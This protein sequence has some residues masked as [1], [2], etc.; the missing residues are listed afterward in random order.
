MRTLKITLVL[1][2]AASLASAGSAD[3]LTP[4]KR[5]VREMPKVSLAKM[6]LMRVLAHYE[7]LSGLTLQADWEALGGAGVTKETPVTLKAGKLTFDKLLDL[8]LNSAAK[9]GRPL[10]WYLS[11]STVHVSTQMRVILRGR[12]RFAGRVRPRGKSPVR[13]RGTYS[14]AREIN[15]DKTPLHLAIEFLRDLAGTNFH[16]NWRALEESGISR[17][18]PVTVKVS[19]VTVGRVLD[20]VLDQLNVNRDRL[21][22]VY[23][24]I[25]EGV[26]HIATGEV[27]NRN[28]KVRIYDVGDLLMVVPN[29][30]GPRISMDTG[31][32][33]NGSSGGG[34]FDDVG[35][36]GSGVGT[37]SGS[38]SGRGEETD[39]AE[40]RQRLRDNLIET[41][42]NTIGEE[43]WEPTGKGSIKILRTKLIIAQTP[44]GF[45]LL[46][47]ALGG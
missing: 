29:F 31:N 4:T 14:A 18:T 15:F 24:V 16:V 27:L 37:T 30:Q 43:M 39:I 32:A 12:T 21:G 2:L 28:T 35:G 25:Q 45:K 13:L 19:N 41:I 20:L 9:E 38:G 34:L 8:T 36:G 11:G 3:K 22:R 17:E 42:K 6:P 44:L 7:K 10:A 40:Q 5:L 26:V 1:L 33:N 23:W 47:E 46:E